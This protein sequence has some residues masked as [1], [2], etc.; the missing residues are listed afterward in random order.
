MSLN[1]T[2]R[3]PAGASIFGSL[4]VGVV[5]F[6]TPENCPGLGKPTGLVELPQ[7]FEIPHELGAQI[8]LRD[9]L[10]HVIAGLD[11]H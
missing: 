9:H 8:A 2:Q 1:K 6:Q 5:F 10:N 7:G 3:I 11:S 4:A